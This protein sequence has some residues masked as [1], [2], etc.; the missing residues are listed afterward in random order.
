MVVP[1]RPVKYVKDHVKRLYDPRGKKGP[2]S[3]EEDA[4]LL[5]LVWAYPEVKTD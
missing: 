5:R 2:W 3:A 1:G 4:T